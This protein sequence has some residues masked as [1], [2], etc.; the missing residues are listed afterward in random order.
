MSESYEIYKLNVGGKTWDGKEMLKFE[1]IK[2]Q[3]I[4]NAWRAVDDAKIKSKH[5]KI[6]KKS[7]CLDFCEVKKS[8]KIILS[9]DSD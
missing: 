8:D 2:N 6:I 9:F 5:K 7:N 3:T 1:D 4:Q